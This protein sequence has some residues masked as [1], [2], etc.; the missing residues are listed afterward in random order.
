MS[1]SLAP[2]SP[3][4]PK[5]GAAVLYPLMREIQ[6]EFGKEAFGIK[7]L[8]RATGASR[9]TAFRQIERLRAAGALQKTR[10]SYLKKRKTSYETKT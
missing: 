4:P 8:S 2:K 9:P 10:R 7:T 5:I 1:K 6:S 3:T